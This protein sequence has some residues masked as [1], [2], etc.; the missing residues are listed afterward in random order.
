MP[1][2]SASRPLSRAARTLLAVCLL[3]AAVVSDAGAAGRTYVAFGDSYTS[4]LGMPDERA[5]PSGEPKCFRS[6]RNYP[7]LAAE[8]L[9]L[10]AERSG[11]WADFSCANATLSGAALLSPIDLMGEVRLAEKAGA[12]GDDT[13]FVTFSGG[14][15]DRWDAGGFGLFVGAVLCLNN[16]SCGA[17]PPAEGFA[18]PSSV[19]PDAF[20]A[21][22][23]PAVARIRELAPNAKIALVEYPVVLPLSGP[24]CRTD[25]ARTTRAADG[26]AAYARAATSALYTAQ[27]A[28][29]K[30]LGVSFVDTTNATAGHDICQEEGTRWYTR[31]GDRGAD[32]VHPTVDAHAALAKVVYA[33]RPSV[34]RATLRAPSSVR[35]GRTATFRAADL[36]RASGYRARL[37]RRLKVA[38]RVRTCT[39]PV[40][41]GKLTSGDATFKGRVPRTVSCAGVPRASRIRAIPA[42]R[43]TVRV[44]PETSSGACRS[45]G[46][47]ATDR[48][49]VRR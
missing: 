7:S 19:T 28:A 37:T 29:A 16:D 35:V 41:R 27:R 26:S 10:G 34:P 18:Q 22:A 20:V 31:S 24:F 15:N 45:S 13:R 12:L 46:S 49:T 40:G 48:V 23:G 14:G 32:P 17:T 4:G 9:G 43:Y 44:C 42:G 3:G 5:T 11:G 47:T 39:A 6:A 33:A 1:L 30:P 2:A 38:G 36:V 25:L 21:R 8:R